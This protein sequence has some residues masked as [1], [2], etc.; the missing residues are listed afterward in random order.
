ML[1]R[2][3]WVLRKQIEGTLSL[4][5]NKDQTIVKTE[6]PVKIFKSQIFSLIKKQNNQL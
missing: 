6:G 5:M 1:F 2:E 3:K 4:G